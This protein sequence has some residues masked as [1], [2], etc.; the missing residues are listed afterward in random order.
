M[1]EK[2]DGK[3]C[4]KYIKFYIYFLL[5]ENS[6]FLLIFEG[7]KIEILGMLFLKILI[8]N[9][10]DKIWECFLDRDYCDNLEDIKYYNLIDRRIIYNLKKK[11]VDLLVI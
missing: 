10:I 7:I 4:V 3:I 9:I 2:E 1:W 8:N 6:K 11:L 5:F